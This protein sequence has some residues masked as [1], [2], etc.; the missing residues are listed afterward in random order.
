MTLQWPHVLFIGVLTMACN[1]N[2]KPAAD[3][4]S[5]TTTQ[6]TTAKRNDARPNQ[7]LAVSAEIAKACGI[8]LDD[9]QDAPKFDLDRSDLSTQDRE[10]LDKV[11][12]C[13]TTGPLQGRFLS[14]IGRADPRGEEEYNMSL[15]GSRAA[16]VRTYLSRLGVDASRLS[17]TSRGKLDASG[18]DENGWRLDR[19]VDV[20]LDKAK[21]AGR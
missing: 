20:E 7:T 18:T 2:S 10:V 1:K 13:A 14:L 11:A 3:A 15:G 6:S 8:T 12:Q 17:M 5:I 16:S 19:R 4:N 21:V 9:P